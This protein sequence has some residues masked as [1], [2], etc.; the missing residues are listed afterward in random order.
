MQ[1]AAAVACARGDKEE[2]RRLAAL[3]ETTY[4]TA[5]ANAVRSELTRL[6]MAGCLE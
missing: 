3:F 6:G 1:A 5:P 2:A 4:G